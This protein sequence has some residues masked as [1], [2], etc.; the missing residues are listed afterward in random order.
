MVLQ[1]WFVFQGWVQSSFSQVVC[2]SCRC[3]CLQ[4]NAIVK[5]I[6]YSVNGSHFPSS[7]D[8]FEREMTD[9]EQVWKFCY[10]FAAMAERQTKS[11]IISRNFIVTATAWFFRF[12]FLFPMFPGT[13]VSMKINTFHFMCYFYSISLLQLFFV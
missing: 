10:A 4:C 5:K 8:G 11:T 2:Y 1:W 12:T 9:I 3:S 7:K 13:V 6:W